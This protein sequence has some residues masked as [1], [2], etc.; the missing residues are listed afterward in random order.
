[1][2]IENG[3]PNIIVPLETALLKKSSAAA[4]EGQAAQNSSQKAFNVQLSAAVENMNAS[5]ENDT[6]RQDKVETIRKQLAAGTYNISGKDVAD[7]ILN[8]L[9]G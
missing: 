7:K 5:L 2:K 4:K 3:S 1:M 6:V 8:I 9:K